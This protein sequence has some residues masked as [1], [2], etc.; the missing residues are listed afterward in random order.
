MKTL[1]FKVKPSHYH[2]LNRAA[3][4]MNIA[5]NQ[6]IAL[7][8]SEEKEKKPSHFDLTKSTAGWAKTYF[9]D[10]MQ[11]SISAMAGRIG[12][13]HKQ[14]LES[15]KKKFLRYEREGVPVE[16]RKYRKEIKYRKSYGSKRSLGWIPF[17]ADC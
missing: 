13:A 11:M 16:K 15:N 7:Y 6:L 10:T 3:V 1:K 9:A 2:F 8:Y 14:L 5:W 17:T 4:E 12:P